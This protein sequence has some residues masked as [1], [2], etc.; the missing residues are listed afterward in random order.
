MAYP[1]RKKKLGCVDHDR[2]PERDDELLPQ[3]VS[4][5]KKVAEHAGEAKE[6]EEGEA[7][8]MECALNAYSPLP[9]WVQGSVALIGD[10]CHPML[11]YIAQGAA[12]GIEDAAV[13]AAALTCTSD[14]RLALGVFEAVRKERAE[15][16][17][18]SVSGTGKSLHL[19]DGPEQQKRDLAIREARRKQGAG[20]ADTGDKWRDQQW[21]LYM[22]GVDVMWETVEKWGE[23]SAAVRV[24]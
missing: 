24:G 12:N 6:S 18:A 11:P 23:L 10:A 22:W 8:I 2:R 15:K 4:R 17:A 5:D 3:L 1:L 9:T 21:Q 19:P 13:L 16:I 20:E 14:V 7:E